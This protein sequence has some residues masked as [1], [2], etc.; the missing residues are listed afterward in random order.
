MTLHILI[1]GRP[2]MV[3]PYF[4]EKR[5][6]TASLIAEYLP[7]LQGMGRVAVYVNDERGVA[8]FLPTR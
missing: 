7:L 1:D 8:C 4:P 3:A 5:A 6:A 2:R